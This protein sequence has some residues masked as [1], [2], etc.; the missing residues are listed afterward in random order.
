MSDLSASTLD[1]VRTQLDPHVMSQEHATTNTSPPADMFLRLVTV[2]SSLSRDESR[3][4]LYESEAERHPSGDGFTVY[5]VPGHGDLTHCG[6]AGIATLLLDMRQHHADPARHPLGIN[7]HHGDWLMDYIVSRLAALPGTP[8]QL[9]AWF[10]QVFDLVKSLPR[11]LV[12]CY[13]EAIVSAVHVLVLTS[14]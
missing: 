8:H 14:I 10:Q 1:H 3:H 11:C 6:L 12:P 7:L 13:F 2:V 4:V 9:S 5:H